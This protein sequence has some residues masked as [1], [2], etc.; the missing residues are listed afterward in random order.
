MSGTERNPKEIRA[1]IEH[2]LGKE[3]SNEALKSFCERSGYAV[4]GE[5]EYSDWLFA[6]EH[7]ERF[8]KV[9]PSIMAALSKWQ[10]PSDFLSETDAVK[11]S[12]GNE[13]VETEICDIMEKGGILYQEIDL[14]T[15]NLGEALHAL[16]VNAGTR[17]S[18]MCAAVFAH[19]TKA[20]YGKTLPLSVLAEVHRTEIEKRKPTEPAK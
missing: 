3:V 13:D 17:S 1:I 11:V 15:K 18:N 12:R 2:F 6:Y 7:D 10:Y 14:V 20:K 4:I 9:M 19:V 16:L 8:K 5:G